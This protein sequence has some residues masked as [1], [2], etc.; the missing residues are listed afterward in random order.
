[1]HRALQLVQIIFE[2]FCKAVQY[3]SFIF[4]HLKGDNAN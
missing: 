1:M 4:A 3:F 2:T